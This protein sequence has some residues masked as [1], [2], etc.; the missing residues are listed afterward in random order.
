MTTHVGYLMSCEPCGK[1]LYSDRR[2]AKRALRVLCPQER[3]RA[4]NAYPCPGGSLGWHIGHRPGLRTPAQ[5]PAWREADTEERCTRCAATIPAGDP[6]ATSD[7]DDLCLDC[8][9]LA[10]HELI[11]AGQFAAPVADRCRPETVTGIDGQP[12]TVA[13]LGARRMNDEDRTHLEVIVQAA[14][15]RH[16]TENPEN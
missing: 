9:D 3:G 13:V 7:G 16:A 5:W 1:K 6:V 4:M 10:E 2:E 12:I 11:L 14:Q 15:R 8:G